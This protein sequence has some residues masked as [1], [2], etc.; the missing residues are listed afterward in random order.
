MPEYIATLKTAPLP[1]AR[2]AASAP[3]YF[4]VVLL[5]VCVAS[6]VLLV[7]WTEFGPLLTDSCSKLLDGSQRC[8][9]GINK[10]WI[11]AY[12]LALFPLIVLLQRWRPAS[13]DQP[14][15]GSG[16]VVDCCWFIA[17]P[18][19]GVWLPTVFEEFLRHSFGAGLSN[20]RLGVLDALPT[21]LK[22]GVVIL[23]ADFLA[24]LSHVIRHKVPLF[25]EFHK[26][27]HSQ[28]QLNYFSTLRQH[29]LDLIAN[30]LIRFLPFTL[31]GLQMAVPAFIGW[32]SFQ[33]CYEMYVHANIRTHMGWLRFVLVTPQSHRIH[34]SMTT[35]HIDTNYG[36]IFS[37]WDFLFG[38][39]V[40]D[41]KVYPATGV[42][43]RQVPSARSAT[44]V[45]AV[46]T[47]VGE[48]LYPFVAI[49]R[50]LKRPR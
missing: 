49:A 15:F 37:I 22:V 44:P 11:Y 27:H 28:V 45:A 9:S 35:E 13:A 20:F 29:P 31:L 7:G 41:C 3:T 12:S 50:M 25:W 26:I 24:W 32:I 40:R 18:I 48:L 33:R 23:A 19:L 38:T 46:R 21:A 43:D 4:V 16:L 8:G 1:V 39:Q 36:N 14:T 47:F 34:H 5:T 6:L 10:I 30:S 2:D 17:F 42:H